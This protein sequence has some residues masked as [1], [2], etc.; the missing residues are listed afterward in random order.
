MILKINRKGCEYHGY[1]SDITRTWPIS[2]KFTPIQRTLYEVVYYVQKELIELCNEFPTLNQ[3]YEA[4]IVLLA[5][6]LKE[7]GIVSNKLPEDEMHK[8]EF[9]L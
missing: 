8:V 3:L 7:S 9:L 6:G 5:N 2:G 4:M 1:C